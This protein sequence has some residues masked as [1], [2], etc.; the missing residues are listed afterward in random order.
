MKRRE[1]LSSAR[2]RSRENKHD[3]KSDFNKH[4][5]FYSAPGLAPLRRPRDMALLRHVLPEDVSLSEVLERLYPIAFG[6]G[7]DIGSDDGLA[8]LMFRLALEN[9]DLNVVQQSRGR[10]SLKK[11]EEDLRFFRS[12]CK[13]LTRLERARCAVVSVS[14]LSQHLAI[15]EHFA[16]GKRTGKFYDTLEFANRS[17]RIATRFR[18]LMKLHPDIYEKEY[19]PYRPGTA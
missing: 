10:W 6:R 17:R 15:T 12:A 19:K 9:T 7:V 4:L 13:T 2:P 3:D 11:V 1:P 16:S 5:A 8:E 18:R 14:K